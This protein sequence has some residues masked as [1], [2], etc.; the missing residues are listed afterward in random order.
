M[1]E[2][3]LNLPAQAD[4]QKKKEDFKGYTLEQLK[5]QRAMMALRV[6][7]SKEQLIQSFEALKPKK[8]A[9][10]KTS[11]LGPKFAFASNLAGKI[12]S[13]LNVLDYVMIGMSAFGTAKKAISLFRKK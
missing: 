9:T 2:K 10:E 13:N 5:Y 12:F 4:E 7:F 1:A 3:N 8:K 6:E 11:L